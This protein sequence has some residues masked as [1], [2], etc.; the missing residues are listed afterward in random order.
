VYIEEAHARDEWP[1]GA[2]ISCIDQPKTLEERVSAAREFVS[3][4]DYRIPVLIDSMDNHF[5]KAFAVWPF[6]FYVIEGGRVALKAEPSLTSH[7]YDIDELDRWLAIRFPSPHLPSLPSLLST[8]LPSPT[9]VIA[10]A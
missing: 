1:I 9:P 6:R 8:S 2:T 7:K 5:Q 4:F 10:V 3:E